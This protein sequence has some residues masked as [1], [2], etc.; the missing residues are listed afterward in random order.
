MFDDAA[1]IWRF[2]HDLNGNYDP[3]PARAAEDG[4]FC[5]EVFPALALPSISEEFLGRVG[6]PRYNPRNRNFRVQD[7]HRVRRAV[8]SDARRLE[9]RS[10]AEW[11]D[12]LSAVERPKKADQDRLDAAICLLIAIS[13]R[14]EPRDRSLMIGDLATGYMISPASARVRE[15]LLASA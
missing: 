14:I 5:L 13:W 4:L 10:L 3:A 8:S 1:P 6:R 15:K 9:C 2:L 7:W 12:Q 11:C